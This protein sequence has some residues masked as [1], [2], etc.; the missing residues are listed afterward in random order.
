MIYELKSKYNIEFHK[1]YLLDHIKLGYTKLL[2]S[3]NADGTEYKP[4]SCD[5]AENGYA[6]FKDATTNDNLYSWNFHH[7]LVIDEVETEFKIADFVLESPMKLGELEKIIP[8]GNYICKYVQSFRSKGLPKIGTLNVHDRMVTL[9]NKFS[10][11][12]R[13]CLI[14]SVKSIGNLDL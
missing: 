11:D 4:L 5:I 8:K 12:S 6:S 9:D 1:S 14:L 13:D 2:Y 3:E 10:F 7:A